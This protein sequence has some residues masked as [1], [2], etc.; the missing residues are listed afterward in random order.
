MHGFAPEVVT[1]TPAD[2]TS[3]EMVLA[4]SEPAR[5]AHFDTETPI[6]ALVTF[7][8]S[9]D[10]ID[11]PVAQA[12]DVQSFALDSHVSFDELDIERTTLEMADVCVAVSSQIMSALFTQPSGG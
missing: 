7:E 2:F 5:L 9:I 4:M 10:E 11:L 12:K 1:L 6:D 3:P 8:L